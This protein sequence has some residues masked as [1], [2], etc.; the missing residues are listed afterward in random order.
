[1]KYRI[2]LTGNNKTLIDD[3]F[4]KS[5]DSF[6]CQNT[7]ARYEDMIC[8]ME[9]F[10]PDAFLYCLNHEVPD[11]FRR[12]PQLKQAPESANTAFFVIGSRPECDT[13]TRTALDVADLVMIKP[14]GISAMEEQMINYLSNR[15]AP[16]AKV[17]QKAMTNTQTLTQTENKFPDNNEANTNN[18]FESNHETKSSMKQ[19]SNVAAQTGSH[20]QS[21]NSI[22]AGSQTQKNN[23]VWTDTQTQDNS[24]VHTI[25]HPPDSNAAKPN[26][27]IQS[28]SVL[29][30]PEANDS[31]DENDLLL[32][33]L[34][35]SL[36]D[37]AALLES[38][39][40]II[41][42]D[43]PLRRKHIL[44]VDDDSRMLKIINR[45]LA[46]KYDVATA[47][48]GRLALK[49]LETKRTDLILLD[50]EMPLENGPA[51]L[52]KIRENPRTQNIPVV[53]LTGISERNKIQ[54]ALV[55]KPQ[56]YLLKPIDHIKLLSTISKL[57][58]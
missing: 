54:K 47:L 7:S 36:D 27:S 38:V 25:S 4:T 37:A 14:L 18:S 24:M 12:I 21:N 55:L 3:F 5:S 17:S 53:F 8:H 44:V 39:S 35:A 52:K 46:E 49:F 9:Y 31:K 20:L 40:D 2:L 32:H 15:A 16:E 56:G 23:T 22:Q 13:F 50:Y 43:S 42:E 45:H 58:G 33:A 30:S 29:K 10:H 51:I 28:N 34:T 41:E 48:N 11:S 26:N 19:Q 6:E 1:M 57:I